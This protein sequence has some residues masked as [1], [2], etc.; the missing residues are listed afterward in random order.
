[1]VSPST[2]SLFFR[3]PLL[4]KSHRIVRMLLSRHYFGLF[5]FR[6][7]RT[8]LVIIVTPYRHSPHSQAIVG[9][10]CH[11]FRQPLLCQSAL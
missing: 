8:L 9:G 7:F 11:L 6:L 4:L 10:Y 2:D 5:S 1:L 3:Q